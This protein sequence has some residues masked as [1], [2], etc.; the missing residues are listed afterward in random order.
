MKQFEGFGNNET[1]AGA[2]V[3]H[4]KHGPTKVSTKTL[5]PPGAA[6]FRK[7]KAPARQPAP[8]SLD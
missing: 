8:P 6:T 1:S 2:P 7:N 3:F 4:P 5:L